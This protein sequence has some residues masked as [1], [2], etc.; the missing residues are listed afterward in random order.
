MFVFSRFKEG[1]G[2]W[3]KRG[4]AAIAEDDPTGRKD[5]KKAS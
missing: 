4:A 5:A 1:V 2:K 3:T